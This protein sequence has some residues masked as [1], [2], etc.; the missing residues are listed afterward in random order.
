MTKPAVAESTLKYAFDSN[1]R[2]MPESLEYC[3]LLIVGVGSAGNSTVSRLIEMGISSANCIAINTDAIQLKDSKANRKILIGEK[4][5]KGLSSRNDPKLGR[6]AI[7][8][9]RGQIEIEV[10]LS[11]ADIVLITAGLDGRKGTTV[12]PAVAEIARRKGALTVGVI[13]APLHSEKGRNKFAEKALAEMKRNCDTVVVI[14]NDKLLH[15]AP[16][17]LKS[18]A[19]RAADLVLANMI[20]GLVETVSAPSLIN[21]NFADFKRIVRK[22]GIATVGVGESN[23]PNRAE[24]AVRNAFQNPLLDVNYACATGALIHV[25]GDHHLT[26]EEANRVGEIVT[27]IMDGRA[28]VVWGACVNP[29]QE[30][31]LKVTLLMTGINSRNSNQLGRIM[32]K[33]YD[34]EPYDGPEKTLNIDLNLYQME[35]S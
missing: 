12:A 23:A 29:E 13:T 28:R 1:E 30:G 19:F 24:E 34:L 9:S 4:I 6:L 14:D 11:E 27:E 20:K 32:T 31:N 25:T 8:E 18:D 22:G 17:L 15:L 10:A 16:Q 21:L 2:A 7:E 26:V 5:T 3:R 35:N 33:I